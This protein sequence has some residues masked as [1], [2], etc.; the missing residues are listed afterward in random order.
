MSNI[1][2]YLGVGQIDDEI[3][4]VHDNYMKGMKH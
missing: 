1:D 3:A 2:L 4:N